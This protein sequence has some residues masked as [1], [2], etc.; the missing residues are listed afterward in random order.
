[1]LPAVMTPLRPGD[2][3]PC[4]H[5]ALLVV[6]VLTGLTLLGPSAAAIPSIDS[7][8][9]GLPGD[10]GAC[11]GR[12][13]PLIE[14][15]CDTPALAPELAGDCGFGPTDTASGSS[16]ISHAFLPA[17]CSLSIE[18]W[19]DPCRGCGSST[20]REDLPTLLGPEQAL[21]FV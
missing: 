5:R 4:M 7:A 6:V 13:T 3:R 12:G 2:Q 1:M 10:A 21:S 16:A 11:Y 8:P 9:L 15:P 14:W 20:V 18:F 17:Y 19:P